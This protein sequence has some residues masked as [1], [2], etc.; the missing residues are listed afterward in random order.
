M[1]EDV[2]PILSIL[3][4]LLNIAVMT[5]CIVF[6]TIQHTSAIHYALAIFFIFFGILMSIVE[7][8]SMDKLGG[9]RTKIFNNAS[10]LQ[11]YQGRAVFYLLWG[12]FVICFPLNSEVNWIYIFL[13][14]LGA[15][16]V[17]LAVVNM[18]LGC[19]AR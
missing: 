12:I 13:V 14:I 11:T 6:L 8:P 16:L 18:I 19:K 4:V 1:V 5:M 9:I 17:V 7:V 3:A 10:M 15:S 2:N